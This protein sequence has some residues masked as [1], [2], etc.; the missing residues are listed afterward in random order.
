M[1]RHRSGIT[2]SS[3]ADTQAVLSGGTDGA[4]S[5]TTRRPARCMLITS[6]SP[7][8][9]AT[10]RRPRR[11]FIGFARRPAMLLC[12]LAFVL[13]GFAPSAAT[14]AVPST[15]SAPYGTDGEVDGITTLGNT[16]YLGG[17][18]NHVGL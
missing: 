8:G 12:V 3:F 14:A 5:A 15:P 4:G 18:F 13:A 16:I 11:M 9:Q 7:T 6:R 10:A 17:A 2:R 1:C